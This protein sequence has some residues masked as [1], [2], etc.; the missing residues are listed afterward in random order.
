MKIA[1]QIMINL[2][3]KN[4]TSIKTHVFGNKKEIHE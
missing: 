1:F 2:Y 4:N 3:L